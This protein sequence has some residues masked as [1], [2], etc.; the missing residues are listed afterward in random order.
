[1]S[2]SYRMVTTTTHT[3]SSHHGGEAHL[4]AAD[5]FV[6]ATEKEKVEMQGLNSRLEVYIGRVKQLE[7]TNKQLV[8][9]LDQLRGSLGSDVGQIKFKFNDSL[10]KARQDIIDAATS[11]I[12]IEVRVNR[13]RDDLNDYRNRYEEARREIDREKTSW[14]GAIAQAT[15]EL[16]NNKSRY[17]A[18]LDEEKRLYGEQENLYAQLASA[19]D[20]LDAAIAD[21]LRLQ[22][23][24]EGLRTELEFLGRVHSQEIA[25]LRNLLSHAPADTREFFKTELAQAIRDI[26]AEYDKIIQTTKLDLE[27]IFQ[28]K[29]DAIEASVSTRT[30]AAHYRQEEIIKMNSSITSLR[31]KLAELEAKN[32]ELER[33][34]NSLNIQL[35]D[36]Q[37]QYEQ[38]LLKRDNQ[39]R[40]MRED[41]QTL[42]AE[43]QSLLNTKQTLDTEIAIYRKLVESEESRVGKFEVEK[44]IWASGEIRS[45]FKR[46]AKGNVSI[47]ECDPTG[48]FIILE[49]TSGTVTESIGGF[50]IRRVLDGVTAFTYTLPSP[51]SIHP[52]GHLKIYGKSAGG[53]HSPPE[54]I[55]ME[56][57]P[58]WGHGHRVETTLYNL[59]GAEKASHIQTNE[60][61]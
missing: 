45:T 28:S 30:D 49:N 20:E 2:T 32:H 53:I 33:E 25:E 55:V 31:A 16:E 12:N 19:K 43:L 1:M 22:H 8:I 18:I 38:E 17:A 56:S 44:D 34:A 61:H 29:I 47:T 21:R 23:Q 13:L 15:A 48:R 10:S 27:T 52:R 41:C 9:E 5:D 11:S 50:Q 54:T 6:R 24:E 57:H 39:L 59:Q 40:F 37:R 4:H 51:L 14:G 58:S 35:G 3:S 46:H 60:S 7:E 36:D 42:I 26:K